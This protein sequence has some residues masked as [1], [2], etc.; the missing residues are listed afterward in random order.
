MLAAAD[1]GQTVVASI[2]GLG[3]AGV[4]G[5]V[6]FMAW[7]LHL[8]QLQLGRRVSLP[9]TSEPAELAELADDAIPVHAVNGSANGSANGHGR[10]CRAGGG[11]EPPGLADGPRPGPPPTAIEGP[12]NVVIG[13]E[14]R[15]RVR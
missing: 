3:A 14:A 1:V 13:E 12:D 8:H 5:G 10:A 9:E 15:Y 4:A 6:V 7:S 11:T 2:L